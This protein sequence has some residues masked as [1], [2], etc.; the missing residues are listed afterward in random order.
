MRPF[1]RLHLITDTRPGREPLAVVAAALKVAGSGLAVQVRVEDGAT[2]REAYELAARVRA[3]CAEARATCLVNDRLHIALAVGAD[4]GHVGALD[5]PVEA[6]RR[7]LGPR[8]ILGATAREPATA[9]AAVDGGASYLGV[10]PA[11]ATTTKDG[12]PPPIGV[13]GI[14]AVAGA[15]GVPVIAIAGVTAERIPELRAAGAYGVAVIGAL[16]AAPDPYR[17]TEALRDALR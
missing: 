11:Y 15:V 1:P 17:A 16:S 8:A 6:A 3:L 10:G 9:K 4:G 12:L 14:A 7:V 13:E 5:L 2:D